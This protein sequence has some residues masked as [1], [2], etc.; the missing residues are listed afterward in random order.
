MDEC[1]RLGI[2][3]NG[4]GFQAGMITQWLKES[5]LEAEELNLLGSVAGNYCLFFN[6]LP[7]PKSTNMSNVL[8]PCPKNSSVILNPNSP[9]YR[10]VIGYCPN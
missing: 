3:P 5:G 2:E 4:E 1:K 8:V 6:Y 10:N 7:D 9:W